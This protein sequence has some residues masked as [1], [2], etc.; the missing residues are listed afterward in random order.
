MKIVIQFILTLE[1]SSEQIWSVVMFKTMN[2]DELLQDEVV[3][4]SSM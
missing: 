2:D 3:P 1:G 4:R